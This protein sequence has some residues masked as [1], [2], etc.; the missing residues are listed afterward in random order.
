MD[1]ARPGVERHTRG[2]L[3]VGGGASSRGTGAAL[4]PRPAAVGCLARPR[5]S[6]SRPRLSRLDPADGRRSLRLCLVV[7]TGQLPQPRR[8]GAARPHHCIGVAFPQQLPAGDQSICA[9][10]PITAVHTQGAARRLVR[11][12]AAIADDGGKQRANGSRGRAGHHRLCS[13]AHVARGHAGAP[14]LPS[15]SACQP[16]DRAQGGDCGCAPPARA[17]PRGRH[18]LGDGLSA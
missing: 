11:V 3:A 18:G 6:R 14:P 1:G 10:V 7:R 9:R 13:P 4:Q 5:A 17:L 12:G 16:R 2:H 8:C 15:R